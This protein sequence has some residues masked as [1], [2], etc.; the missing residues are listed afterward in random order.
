[1]PAIKYKR[2]FNGESSSSG[3]GGGGSYTASNV[4]TGT[5]VFNSLVSNNFSFN[6]I[7]PNSSSV[8]VSLISNTIRL[9]VVPSNFTGIP[10][11]GVTNLISSLAKNS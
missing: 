6:S 4:G 2:I 9:D 5:G 7:A 8:S 1:M 3:G 11:S 10:Q